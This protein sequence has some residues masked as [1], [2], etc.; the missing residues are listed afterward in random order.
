MVFSLNALEF[1]N[2]VI[3]YGIWTEMVKPEK[4]EKGSGMFGKF[5]TED[6]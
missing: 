1:L 2:Q 5:K 3:F 6:S 4:T